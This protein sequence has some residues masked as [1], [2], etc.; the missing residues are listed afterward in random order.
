MRQT[1][2]VD[3]GSEGG[4][5]V[6]P[7][8]TAEIFWVQMSQGGCIFQRNGFG[9]MGLD[10]LNHRFEAMQIFLALNPGS[11]VDCLIRAAE[12]KGNPQCSLCSSQ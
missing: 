8:K 11:I 10:V 2:A 6:P 1:H 12:Q 5:H 9:V 7:K 3:I 4:S